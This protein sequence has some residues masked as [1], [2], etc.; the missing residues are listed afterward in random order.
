[1]RR[2]EEAD[3]PRRRLLIR[4]LAAGFFSASL[5]G[6]R[7]LA[8]A[9]GTTPAALPPGRSIYRID[10]QVL[11][12]GQPATLDTRIGGNSTVE[13]L[14]ASEV[15][16]AVGESAFI[17]RSES[18]VTMA[19]TE[20]DSVILAGLHLLTGKI[21]SVFPSGKAVRLSTKNATIGIRGTGVYMESDPEQTYF[22]T[23]Y[24]ISDVVATDDPTSQETVAATHHDKP[25]YILTGAPAGENIRA[26]PFLNH[27]DQEL[28]LI[29][30]LVGRRTPFVFPGGQ[31]QGPRRGY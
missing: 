21:L 2:V 14:S 28:M 17:Q 25:L 5:A 29:E 16:Y 11:V 7:A 31:Y 1:M 15:V 24:G 27:T 19:A 20:P 6:R 4:A 9:L 30:T 10:G 26:A 8:Q 23:C 3:D 13:T 22:C 18:R 12:D